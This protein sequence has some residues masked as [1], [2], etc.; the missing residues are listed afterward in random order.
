MDGSV[1]KEAVV[2]QRRKDAGQFKARA[3]AEVIAGHKTVNEISAEYGVHA[4]QIHG[5]KKQALAHLPEVLDDK[6]CSARGC[7]SALTWCVV[8]CVGWVRRRFIPRRV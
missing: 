4:S 1:R 7:G 6:R 2:A 3:A 5:R 8:C